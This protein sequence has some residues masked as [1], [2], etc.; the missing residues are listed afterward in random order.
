MQFLTFYESHPFFKSFVGG[1]IVEQLQGSHPGSPLSFLSPP[2]VS[3]AEL[4]ADHCN[5]LPWGNTLIHKMSVR[6]LI[7]LPISRSLSCPSLVRIPS[8]I[9]NLLPILGGKDSLVL[10]LLETWVLTFLIQDVKNWRVKSMHNN[11]IS[12]L[13]PFSCSVCHW[14]PAFWLAYVLTHSCSVVSLGAPPFAGWTPDLCYHSVLSGFLLI[15][16]S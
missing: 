2:L 10:L 8:V 11:H 1:K 13:R 5:R 9:L 4:F 6:I 12:A 15:P 14:C 3:S 16:R 7:V